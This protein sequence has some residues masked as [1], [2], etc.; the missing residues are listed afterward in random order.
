[1]KPAAAKAAATVEPRGIA[2]AKQRPQPGLMNHSFL[3]EEPEVL[4]TVSPSKA[5][6]GDLPPRK[7]FLDRTN[8]NDT[9][10][11]NPK[12][13]LSPAKVEFTSPT[14][15]IKDLGTPTRGSILTP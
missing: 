12:M 5:Q 1:E 6:T 3:E 8:E 13:L 11:L 9:D 4:D 7:P 10:V 15:M 14:R 2:P